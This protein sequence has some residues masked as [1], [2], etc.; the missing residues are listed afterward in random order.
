MEFEQILEGIGVDFRIVS[1]GQAAVAAWRAAAPDLILMDVSMPVMNGLQ[2]TQAIRDAESASGGE[3]A[4]V[5]I[6]A[7]TAHAMGGDRERCFAAGMDD[8]L[9]KPVSPEKLETMIKK[10]IEC[11][12]KVF[13]AG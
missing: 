3:A 7:V 4:H 11:S 10:W 13:A 12:D 9:S 1:D 5:P 6:I 2:A 8:Y